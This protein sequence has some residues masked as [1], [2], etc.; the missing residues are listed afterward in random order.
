MKIAAMK[1]SLHVSDEDFMSIVKSLSSGAIQEGHFTLLMVL[2]MVNTPYYEIDDVDYR[3]SVKGL[4]KTL[5]VH[6]TT[7]KKRL[8]FLVKHKI[9]DTDRET[10]RADSRIRVGRDIW[11]DRLLSIEPESK[12]KKSNTSK[13]DRVKETISQIKK[14]LPESKRGFSTHPKHF[15]SLWNLIDSDIDVVVYVGWL[16]RNYK[17]FSL[18]LMCSSYTLSKFR[19]VQQGERFRN[20][21]RASKV[22]NEQ[23]ADEFWSER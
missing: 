3:I 14:L 17:Y 12:V 10:F 16:N 5:N 4:A 21:D 1:S 13:T 15:R 6:T 9:I 23:E 19:D 7:I 20:P 18:G 22:E 2:S 8:E 11:F